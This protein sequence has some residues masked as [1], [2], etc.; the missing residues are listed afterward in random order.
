MNF[1]LVF[2]IRDSCKIVQATRICKLRCESCIA[3][4]RIYGWTKGRSMSLRITWSLSTL[5]RNTTRGNWSVF[6]HSF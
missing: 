6:K 1:V 3:L 5:P 4:D 2:I